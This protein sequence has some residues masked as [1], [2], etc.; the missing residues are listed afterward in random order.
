MNTKM[1]L[2][3]VTALL[4]VSATAFAD[5]NGIEVTQ[6]WDRATPGN[7]KTGAIYLTITNKGTTPDTLEGQASSPVAAQADVHEMKMVNNVMEMRPVPSLTIPPGQSVVF[8]PSGYHV[9][10]TGL[11]APLKEGQ[12]VPLTLTFAHAGT[13]HVTA[14]VA[15]VGAMHA[16]DMSMPSGSTMSGGMSNMSNMPG[17]SH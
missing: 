4:M 14:A 3:L 12:S 13:Q 1:S 2:G 15:K 16:G 7:V 6:V 9:M 11:K 8:E 17:M 5:P 10:L